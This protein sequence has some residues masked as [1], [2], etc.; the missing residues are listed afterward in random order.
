MTAEVE[1]RLVGYLSPHIQRA[2]LGI[3]VKYS[4]INGFVLQFVVVLAD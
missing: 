3:I 1:T 2:A 4:C